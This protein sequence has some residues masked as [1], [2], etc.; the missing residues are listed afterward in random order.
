M[1]PL[2]PFIPDGLEEL[3]QPLKSEMQNMSKDVNMEDN[4]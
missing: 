2:E 1:D 3:T 4:K